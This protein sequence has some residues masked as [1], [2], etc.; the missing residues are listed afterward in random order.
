MR[1]W[2][3]ATP[4]PPQTPKSRLDPHFSQ[5]YAGRDEEQAKETA[6]KDAPEKRV[7]RS[8]RHECIGVPKCK[9]G[10]ETALESNVA[11]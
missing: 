8:K 2:A 7:W 11:G 6:G 1:G 4:L 3:R 10:V 5:D 9:I